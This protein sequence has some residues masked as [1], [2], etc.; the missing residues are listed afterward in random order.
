[1]GLTAYPAGGGEGGGGSHGG[2][3]GEPG[4]DSCMGE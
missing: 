1:M 3:P 2:C 4:S